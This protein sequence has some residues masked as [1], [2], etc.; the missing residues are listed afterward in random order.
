MKFE[1]E[2]EADF[3][4]ALDRLVTEKAK[5]VIYS[6]AAAMAR[7]MYDEVRLNTSG[8][9][10]GT[11][12]I[13]T[14][15]LHEAIYWAQDKEASSDTVAEYGISWN[16]SKAPHGHLLEFG[17]AHMAAKPFVRPALS[18]MQEA[19][20]EGLARMRQRYAE[21]SAS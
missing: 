9:R 5:P 7:V 19:I 16:K 2:L 21:V 15:A 18:R 14:G 13:V 20:N 10:V 17:T 12:G 3:A 1:A 11:P 6:G 8:A 4:E